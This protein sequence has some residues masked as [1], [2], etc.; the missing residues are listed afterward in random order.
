MKSSF[1]SSYQPSPIHYQRFLFLQR[2]IRGSHELLKQGIIWILDGYKKEKGLGQGNR[3]GGSRQ[4]I[5]CS[6]E[7]FATVFQAEVG[8]IAE[9]AWASLMEGNR[10]HSIVICSDNQAALMTLYGFLITSKEVL[11]CRELLEKLA[12]N[13]SVSLLWV[14][15]RALQYSWQWKVW[16][17]GK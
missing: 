12:I 6:L 9:C 3:E 17:T 5:V 7:P 4:E 8:A 2:L 15:C 16:Q 13:N 14:P 10:N 1:W 11:K